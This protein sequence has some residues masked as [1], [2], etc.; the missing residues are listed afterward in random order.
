MSQKKKT[1]FS[2]AEFVEVQNSFPILIVRPEP[3]TNPP[4]GR[5]LATSPQ[6]NVGETKSE[7][8]A[9]ENRK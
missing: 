2:H 8:K 3:K 9:A 7:N 6:Q 1:D 4:R 5:K